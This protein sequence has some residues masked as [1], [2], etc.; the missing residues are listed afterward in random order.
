MATRKTAV[1]R[2]AK[3]A[4]AL[5]AAE[6]RAL[7]LLLDQSAIREAIDRYFY[8][9]DSRTFKA[10]SSVF[11]ADS[12]SD[13]SGGLVRYEGWKGVMKGIDDTLRGGAISSSNH[14]TTS[15][16]IRVQTGGDTASS[17]THAGVFLMSEHG[18]G[19]AGTVIARGLRYKDE[20]VRTA[21]GWR[22]RYRL[23]TRTWT[24]ETLAVKPDAPVKKG[25]GKRAAFSIR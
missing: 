5:S 14:F 2:S 12:K 3:T 17:D 11:T 21:Q 19:A 25:R 10:F 13:Y 9:V 15:T 16:R 8:C 6:T 1:Q 24:L 18:Q 7:R 20:W 22:I 4:A 23:H